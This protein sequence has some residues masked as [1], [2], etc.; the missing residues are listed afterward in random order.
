[1]F[2]KNY[3]TLVLKA[4]EINL[5]S[6]CSVFKPLVLIYDL[7]SKII[8]EK[9]YLYADDTSVIL[10]STTL[11]EINIRVSTVFNATGKFFVNIG[12]VNFNLQKESLRATIYTKF[13]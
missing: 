6:F 7:P 5:L 9:I 8:N 3:L 11:D 1:M 12:S 13:L 2:Q 10:S 4:I